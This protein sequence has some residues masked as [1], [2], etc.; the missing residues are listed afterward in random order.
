M[1]KILWSSQNW[2][3]YFYFFLKWLLRKFQCVVSPTLTTTRSF[4]R[5]WYPSLIMHGQVWIK[6]LHATF[7]ILHPLLKVLRFWWKPWM[8]MEWLTHGMLQLLPPVLPGAILFQEST[9][10]PTQWSV[11][12]QLVRQIANSVRPL[13]SGETSNNTRCLLQ[14]LFVKPSI[15]ILFRLSIIKQHIYKTEYNTIQYNTRLN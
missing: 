7:A 3:N 9:A 13:V 5:R 12:H 14:W 8:W 1:V 15:V 2:P 11:L 10:L 6:D 4:L